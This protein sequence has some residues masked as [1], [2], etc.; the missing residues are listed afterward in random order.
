MV[1][2]TI[3]RTRSE[4][5]NGSTNAVGGFSLKKIDPFWFKLLFLNIENF[6]YQTQPEDIPVL[7]FLCNPIAEHES[8]KGENEDIHPPRKKV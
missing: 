5:G 2:G 3:K 8:E 1:A 7:E 6:K 4:F